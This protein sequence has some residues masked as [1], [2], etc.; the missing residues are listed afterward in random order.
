MAEQISILSQYLLKLFIIFTHTYAQSGLR[1]AAHT[2]RAAS[3]A[4]VR[5]C[6]APAVA[7]EALWQ[8]WRAPYQSKIWY[9]G[10]IPI[11]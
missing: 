2:K 9:G 5:Q 7:P 10:D 8:I 4:L 11:S 6:Y 3:A 1:Y